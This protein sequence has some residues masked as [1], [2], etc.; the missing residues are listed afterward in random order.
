M[1]EE[2]TPE[3]Y[4]DEYGETEWERLDRDFYGRL[5]YEETWHFLDR[6]L[7]G[8][9]RVLDV[10]GGA[11]RYSVELAERGYDVTLVDPSSEQVALARENADD[12]GVAGRTTVRVGDVRDLAADPD[13]FDAT[14]CLGGPLSHVL[15]A[16]ERRD[17]AAELHRVTAPGGP[18]F[19]SVMGRLAALQTIARM[20]G[21]VD[22]EV[23]ETELLPRLA[24]TGDYDA[25]L[26]DEFGLDPSGPPMHL[27]RAHELRELL[28][29]A[30]LAVHTLTGLESVASQRRDEFDALGDDHRE[31]IRETVAAL[32]GDPGVADLSGHLLAVA[33]A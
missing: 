24:R 10:G 23:D 33:T 31:A 20:A 32:R 6:E 8:V 16:E 11:G 4:Y 29:R 22:P 17:A 2:F 21:R 25:D 5:E 30:G 12:H 18:V 9:G 14:L 3:A 26:L 27:F 15:D 19:V 13:S 7:P 1:P 28:Q